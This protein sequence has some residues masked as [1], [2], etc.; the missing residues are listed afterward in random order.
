M[1]KNICLFLIYFISNISFSFQIPDKYD[2]VIN[3]QQ[4]LEDMYIDDK[5][6]N[7]P[8]DKWVPSL[9]TPILIVPSNI[10]IYKGNEM[11]SSFELKN[12]LFN[13]N[14]EFEL[15]LF[16]NVTFLED[17][18]KVFLARSVI[19]NA[20][21][22][23]YL[24]LYFGIE[25]YGE[26]TED[27]T[28]LNILK[29]YKKIK[30]KV[31]SFDIWDLKNLKFGT[32]NTTFYF[33][34]SHEIFNSN[35]G[36]IGTCQSDPKNPFWG[37]QFKEM[38]FNNFNIPLKDDQGEF[39]KI[40]FVTETYNIIFPLSFKEKFNNIT[41]DICKFNKQGF[42]ACENF[43][44]ENDFVPL[45]L[46]EENDNMIITGQVDSVNRFD[47]EEESKKDFVRIVFEEIEYIMIPLM[48]FKQF[49]IQF[50]AD[51]NEINFYTND[52][53][54]LKTKQSS[55]KND[56]SSS[57]ISTI[58][59]ILII[60]IILIIIVIIGIRWFIKNGNSNVEKNINKFNKLEEEEDFH[61][62]NENR[63]F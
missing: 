60:L 6:N 17:N 40:Y 44:N 61:N 24:G 19:P 63:V 43:F 16:E 11:H 12:P 39:Y 26:L 46:T 31:F 8:C 49:H 53:T 2:I 38:I 57:G 56:S 4:N 59:I 29:N 51:K 47:K 34:E 58:I 41:N 32:I 15:D 23:C 20:I 45:Q 21:S 27:Q 7:S 22:S 35:K 14:G 10:H 36:V 33:G 50:N 48:V 30:E 3:T 55:K 1:K 52:E 28:N 18:Y 5:N 54:I 9:T 62:I 13:K 42:L 37:C 25:N